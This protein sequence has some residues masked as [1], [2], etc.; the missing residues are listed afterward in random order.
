MSESVSTI[1]P[2]R[3]RSTHAVLSDIDIVERW[4]APQQESAQEPVPEAI[5][6]Q[7]VPRR[8]SMQ[9]RSGDPLERLRV[10]R[11]AL[12]AV[13]LIVPLLLVYRLAGAQT[14]LRGWLYNPKVAAN[15]SIAQ[16]HPDDAIAPLR[17]A[18]EASP[19]DVEL[20]RKFSRIGMKTLPAEAR[21]C[22]NRIEQLGAT[23]DEDRAA[24]A[25]LLARLHDFRGAKA[26]LSK[27]GSENNATIQRAWLA[28]WREAGDYLA[29]VNTLDQLAASGE[30]DVNT[31]LQLVESATNGPVTVEV[32]NRIEQHLT[33]ALASTTT[34]GKISS[35][36]AQAPRLAALSLHSP[37]ARVEIAK[38]LRSLP[39]NP[40][41]YRM[42]AIRLQFSASP[43]GNEREEL[44]KAWFDEI[45]ACGGL[46]ALEKDH[47][48]TYLQKQGE[49]EL[50]AD[51]I[52]A[53]EA[54]SETS[55]YQRR[56]ESLLELG[57]WKDVGAM[58]AEAGAPTLPQSR[59]LMQSL[60]SLYKPSPQTCMA[61]RLLADAYA[62]SRDEKRAPACFATGCAALDYHLPILASQAFATALDL[63]KD[64]RG[65]MESIINKSRQS[66]LTISQLLRSLEGSPTNQDQTVQNQLIYLHLLANRDLDSMIEVIHNRRTLDPGDV[67][68]RFLDAF[69]AH[70]HGDFAQASRM[71]VPLPRYRWHQ[72]EA[73][74]IASIVAAAG[75]YDRSATLLG[76]ID[77]T[78]LFPEEQALIT[79]W[80]QRIANG[81]NL[82]STVNAPADT[83]TR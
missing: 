58:S 76:Q 34:A 29:A 4:W 18:I 21:R 8:H 38:F 50:V 72:G 32:L 66:P 28:I 12:V 11:Y 40:P 79:P 59:L 44:Q 25:S 43:N 22:F 48:A 42:A 17:R 57:R 39:G 7:S 20:L 46:S 13:S 80:Q 73:A 2:M 60:S 77:T 61:D 19:N 55:L 75:S 70:R 41:E 16:G 14:L 82:V 9:F 6:I 1:R 3:K 49:H 15:T 35:I 26:V 23:T 64:R 5:R 62:E 51:L 68:L 30:A 31:S 10:A 69:A 53:P 33:K 83:T 71:L 81:G 78:K 67:Y 63:A 56:V 54:L 65:L 52:S 37:E 45:T 74:V 24:H 36:A 47:V 27:V